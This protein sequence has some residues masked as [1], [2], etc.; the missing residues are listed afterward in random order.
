M[1]I[2]I[3]G[4]RAVWGVGLQPLAC[5]SCGFESRRWHKCLSV[6]SVVCCQL[7]V[8]ASGWS[9]VQ[10]SP[11]DCSASNSVIV[12]PRLGGG[13]YG[14][15]HRETKMWITRPSFKK[16]KFSRTPAHALITN[17]FSFTGCTNVCMETQ[18]SRPATRLLDGRP[19]TYHGEN[20]NLFASRN[21]CGRM[22]L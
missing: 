11:T 14:L 6:V 2:A 8:C 13:Q 3:P 4:S 5:G 16:R 9:L 7:E 1:L 15:W 12:K 21:T 10:R 19:V 17:T 18:F 22:Y 20:C